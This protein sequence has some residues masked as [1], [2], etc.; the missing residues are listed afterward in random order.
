MTPYNNIL[1][2]PLSYHPS[3]SLS[4][5]LSP[6][7]SLSLTLSLSFYLSLF[8]SVSAL[9][10]LSIYLSIPG[11]DLYPYSNLVTIY[12]ITTFECSLYFNSSFVQSLISHSFH[13]FLSIPEHF[14]WSRSKILHELV[15]SI[16]SYSTM[17][18]IQ[19]C[20]SDS[21]PFQGV[22]DQPR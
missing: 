2:F 14:P 7:P 11:S 13:Q 21:S 16:T 1:S 5:S 4:L 9:I 15:E 17:Q 3:F 19:T 8:I 20:L 6:P 12:E 10:Y 18:T 22:T